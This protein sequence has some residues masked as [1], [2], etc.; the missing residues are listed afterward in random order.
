MASLQQ[1]F[2]DAIRQQA[3]L[4]PQQVLQRNQQWAQP[5]WQQQITKLAPEQEAAFQAWVKANNVPIDLASPH[6]DYDMRGF[7][8]AL[9]AKDPRAMTA[10]NP[11]DKQLHYPDYWKT[12]YHKSFSAESKWATPAAPA[13]RENGDTSYLATPSGHIVFVETP[14]KE[15]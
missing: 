2:Q 9:Q 12:P 5:N 7:W 3:Q 11:T 8:T 10:V 6:P 14:Q 4:V 1:A 13:W 15:K